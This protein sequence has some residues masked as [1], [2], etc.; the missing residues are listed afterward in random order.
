M[1][2]FIRITDALSRLLG[3][4][5]AILLMVAVVVVCQMVFVRYGLNQS[6]SWQ[7]EFVTYTLIASTF[8]GA[9][10][11]LLTRGHVN[12]ELVPLALGPRA[13]FA[14]ALVAYGLAAALCLV[15]TWYS[16][17]FWYE[18]WDGGWSSDTIWA[19][20]LWKVYLA[21]PFGFAALSLQYVADIVCLLLGHQ[22]PFGIADT[23]SET[24]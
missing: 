19:P 1:R 14:L 6:T 10:Y 11:V 20:P 5:A 22:P 12:V 3:V 23:N 9:P 17:L 15:V 18:A 16:A 7:T 8:L 13:R 2:L 21:M 4:V 24:A